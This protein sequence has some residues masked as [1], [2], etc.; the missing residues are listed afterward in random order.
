MV[1]E[2]VY[3]NISDP[4]PPPIIELATTLKWN[5]FIRNNVGIVIDDKQWKSMQQDIKKY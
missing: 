1:G 2:H 5:E 3:M 4:P